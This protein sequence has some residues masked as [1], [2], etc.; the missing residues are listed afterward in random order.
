MVP[1]PDFPPQPFGISEQRFTFDIRIGEMLRLLA[2]VTL[3]FFNASGRHCRGL[4]ERLQLDRQPLSSTLLNYIHRD[5][6][7][8]ARYGT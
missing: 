1:F 6:G 5:S 3:Q 2:R 7:D 8:Q 4:T